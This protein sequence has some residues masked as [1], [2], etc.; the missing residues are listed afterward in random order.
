MDSCV[1]LFYYKKYRL[2][3]FGTKLEI[4]LKIFYVTQCA[5]IR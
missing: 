3:L 2:G 1:M 5:V 4:I